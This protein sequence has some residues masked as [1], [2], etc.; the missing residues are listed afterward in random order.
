[1]SP[2]P[3]CRRVLLMSVLAAAV[4]APAAAGPG[5]AQ[6]I[7]PSGD[8]SGS[9]I[10]YR[11]NPVS[12]ATFYLFWIGTTTAVSHQQ[13]FTAAEAGCGLGTC[14]VTLTLGLPPGPYN[15]FIQTWGPTG[16]GPW[17][18]AK[19]LSLKEGMSS[20][21]RKL[22]SDTRFVLVLDGQ[23]VLDNET[24]LTWE[25]TPSTSTVLWF[26]VG[27]NCAA[28]ETGGRRGWRAPTQSE[29]FSLLDGSTSTG[30]PDG[31]PFVNVNSPG[32]SA[33]FWTITSREVN[34]TYHAYYVVFAKGSAGAP[35]TNKDLNY[36]GFWC[37]RGGSGA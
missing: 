31:A 24:G 28:R 35:W 34:A 17:S 16:Y 19:A 30:L 20:W 7:G 25:R 2:L 15:W 11:W 5:Q 37:V 36:L 10:V 6:L 27:Q 21:S 8:L 9:T 1:M 32:E 29:L 26:D 13:W 3:S 18:A 33:I 4:A 22:T 12:D 23:A 14:A